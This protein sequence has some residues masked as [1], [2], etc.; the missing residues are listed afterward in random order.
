M[1]AVLLL[2]F[3]ACLGFAAA[4]LKPLRTR[5][6]SAAPPPAGLAQK[7]LSEERALRVADSLSPWLKKNGYSDSVLF[8]ADMNLSMHTRRFYTVDIKNKKILQRALVAHGSGGGSKPDSVIFSN[9]PGSN[10]TSPGK[11]KI[12][13]SFYGT[14]GKGYRLHGLDACN[15]NA[16]KRLVVFHYYDLQPSEENAF[17]KYYSEGCPMLSKKDFNLP[18]SIIMA[19]AKPKLLFIYK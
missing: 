13:A 12:G 5:Q 3:L 16:L 6:K 18:D 15:S 11:Y 4:H 9:V 10:C 17:P 2:L 8:L 14:Y 7:K 19:S 1:R